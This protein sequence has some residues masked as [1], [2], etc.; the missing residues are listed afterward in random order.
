MKNGPLV[1]CAECR[2][3]VTGY[4]W[5]G[6][7]AITRECKLTAECG[8]GNEDSTVPVCWWNHREDT[9]PWASFYFFCIYFMVWFL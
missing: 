1:V 2:N 7:S 6:S 4:V 8:L 5:F 3:S 9:T